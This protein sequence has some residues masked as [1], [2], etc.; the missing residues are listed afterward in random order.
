MLRREA[1]RGAGQPEP[2]LTQVDRADGGAAARHGETSRSAGEHDRQWRL[3]LGQ[4][5]EP[6]ALGLDGDR[7]I[8]A[9]FAR[10]LEVLYLRRDEAL[11]SLPHFLVE[12]LRR[13]VAQLAS[14]ISVLPG[15]I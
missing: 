15:L 13:A 9:P 1:L 4:I 8:R 11:A 6:A 10:G 3:R 7:F 12:H 14:A 2:A 5:D